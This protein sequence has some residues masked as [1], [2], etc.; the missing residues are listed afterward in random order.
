ID[1][2]VASKTASLLVEG[3]FYPN[4]SV[5]K[6]NKRVQVEIERACEGDAPTI[7]PAENAEIKPVGLPAKSLVLF[8]AMAI[9]L[10]V[11]LLAAK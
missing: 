11:Y 1:G 8:L 7:A 6:G 4:N 2:M 5:N 10:L 9:C 3:V